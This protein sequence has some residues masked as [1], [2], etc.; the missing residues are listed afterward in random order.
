MKLSVE[1][2][3]GLEF[4]WVCPKCE[5]DDFNS[6]QNAIV[7]CTKCSAIYH[8]EKLIE[9]N[10]DREKRFFEELSKAIS[11]ILKSREEDRKIRRRTG[12]SLDQSKF[13]KKWKEN[14]PKMN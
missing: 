2:Y 14:K 10:K 5:S 11:R 8:F 9:L 7:E 12:V 4:V 6:L 13:S 3:P 1:I